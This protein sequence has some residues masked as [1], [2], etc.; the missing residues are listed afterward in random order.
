LYLAPGFLN[1]LFFVLIIDLDLFVPGVALF[2]AAM[3]SPQLLSRQI[4]SNADPAPN[5]NQHVH[6]C[7][8]YCTAYAGAWNSIQKKGNDPGLHT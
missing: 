3:L 1:L 4:V 8:A 5:V 6:V 2:S 7:L